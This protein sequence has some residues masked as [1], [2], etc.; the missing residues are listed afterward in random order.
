M[1]K[2]T[3]NALG[4][5]LAQYRAVFRKCFLKNA[6]ALAAAGLICCAVPAPAAA[7]NYYNSSTTAT[8]QYVS[9]QALRTAVSSFN[10]G[11][12]IIITS[13]DSSLTGVL[14]SMVRTLLS[15]FKTC[16]SSLHLH[17]LEPAFLL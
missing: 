4:M 15:T 11:D 9:L 13:N 1:L 3:A 10:S 7:V 16:L 17:Q 5:L 6:A 14:N 8:I 2:L 12:K